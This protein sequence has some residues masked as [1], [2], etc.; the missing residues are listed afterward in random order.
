MVHGQGLLVL[1]LG[2]PSPALASLR[3][4]SP[5]GRGVTASLSP[6]E[7]RK[8]ARGHVCGVRAGGRHLTLCPFV[9]RGE[10]ALDN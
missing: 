10:G 7:R 5:K 6:W 3:A 8:H 1:L 9:S 4:A 2:Q